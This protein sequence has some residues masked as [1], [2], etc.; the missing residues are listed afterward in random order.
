MDTNKLII[1]GATAVALI[2]VAFYFLGPGGAPMEATAP[3]ETPAVET[4]A[5]EAPTP[6][7]APET[8]PTPA[9][10]P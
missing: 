4:P 3:A 6:T 10:D 5:A 8:A 1:I 2:L 9:P 7:V